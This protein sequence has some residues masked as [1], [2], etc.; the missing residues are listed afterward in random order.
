MGKNKKKTI[1]YLHG[2]NGDIEVMI[3]NIIKTCFVS[4][5]KPTVLMDSNC[6]ALL[7]KISG[8]ENEDPIIEL[9][10]SKL[11]KLAFLWGKYSS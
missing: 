9:V 5:S 11:K 10:W 7:R 1:L 4:T 8:S 6:W 2:E 3:K